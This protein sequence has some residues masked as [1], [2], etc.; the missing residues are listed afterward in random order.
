MIQENKELVNSEIASCTFVIVFVF[1][2]V[3]QG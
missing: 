2:T 3:I 1:D